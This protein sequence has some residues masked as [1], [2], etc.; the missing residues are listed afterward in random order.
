MRPQT[1]AQRR[2]GPPCKPAS[3]FDQNFTPLRE[4]DQ[5]VATPVGVQS[6]HVFTIIGKG[7]SKPSVFL[8]LAQISPIAPTVAIGSA[9]T[10]SMIDGAGK[11]VPVT[12][13]SSDQTLATVSPEPPTAA[14][15]AVVTGIAAGKPTI[16]VSDPTS[17]VTASVVVTINE[18]SNATNTTLAA[19]PSSLPSTGG[20]VTLTAT[21]AA[22]QTPPAGTPA[23]TGTVTYTDQNGT[24]LCPPVTLASGSAVCSASISA[25]PDTVSANYNGDMNYA[26][27]SG[28]V[29]ITAD[30]SPWVG[31]WDG[32]ITSTCGYISGPWD[33][34]IVSA[35]ADQL[36]ITDNYGDAYNL[37]ISST[38]PNVATSISPSGITYTLGGNSITVTYPAACQT[39]TLTRQ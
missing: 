22:S 21:V 29:T 35:G 9:V 18:G 16:T 11:L 34:V 28:S 19:N 1:L 24:T 4:F 12:W 33:V 38:D 30:V 31:S 37:T 10:L 14:S 26:A 8:R 32:N 27:S 15:S 7:G 17:G 13:Q 25:V 23:P 39:A 20:T 6:R 2:K 5:Y 3:N 36:S